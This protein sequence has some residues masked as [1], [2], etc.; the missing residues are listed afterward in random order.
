MIKVN[1]FLAVS[2]TFF[3]MTAFSFA[4]PQAIVEDLPLID[5]GNA[6]G[7][8]T[9]TPPKGWR[10]ADPK[11][12]SPHVKTLIVGPKLQNEMPPS[13]NLMIEPYRGTLKTYLKQVKKI[14]ETHGDTWKD[15]GTLKTK[16]GDASLS[17][18]EIRSKW[19][20]E[21]LMHA[22]IVKNGY[23]YVLTAT[24]AKNEFGR[25]Y[26]QF[27]SSL[28]SLQIYDNLLEIVKS[29]DK[30]AILEKAIAS[31]KSSF[32][33]AL[34]PQSDTEEAARERMFQNPDFQNNV[35]QPFVAILQKDYA[36]MGEEWQMAVLL[37]LQDNLLS[38]K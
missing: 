4:A 38:Q 37:N 2:L 22:I 10:T 25:F 24:A 29:A 34:D 33:Q 30:R 6:P 9:F 17:Q 35:W 13:M 11:S 26:Q 21:K 5:E 12:L 28:R 27:Y 16:A 32:E 23:A 20:G 18:V 7:I 14:N 31:V 8:A 36:D 1:K 15:L 19:G 3:S